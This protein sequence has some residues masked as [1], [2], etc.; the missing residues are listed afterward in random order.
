MAPIKKYV[1]ISVNENPEYQFY[2]PLVVWAWNKIGWGVILIRTAQN[3]DMD[4]LM[5]KYCSPEVEI[6][7]KNDKYPS[8]MVAQVSRLYAAIGNLD[9]NYIMTSDVDMLPL[10]D[11]WK[12]DPE[13]ITLWGWD[14]TE[15]HHVPMCYVGMKASKWMEVMNITSNDY[16]ELINRDIDSEPN[17]KSTDSQKLWSLD[18]DILTDRINS[19]LTEKNM[20]HRGVYANGYPI[21]R[22]DRSAW[23][24]NHIHYIDCHMH[25]SLYKEGP[26]TNYD[27]ENFMKLL[28]KVWPEESFNWFIKY[29]EEFAKLAKQ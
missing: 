2:I 24:G 11:Y 22:V 10:S 7:L 5:R 14:L 13:M 16:N 8:A 18:Q 4:A 9:E 3:P 1:V 15:Y 28:N 20:V 27:R 17:S 12:F 29:A 25:R 21:G 23:H 6:W 19:C 26:S